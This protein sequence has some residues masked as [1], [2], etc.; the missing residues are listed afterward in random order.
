MSVVCFIDDLLFVSKIRNVAQSL[1]VEIHFVSLPPADTTEFILEKNASRVIIDLNANKFRPID[2]IRAIN[3]IPGGKPN[4]VGFVS[5]VNAELI[6]M[7]RQEG[8]LVLPRSKFLTELDA[9]LR[10]AQ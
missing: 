1:G 5:H 10:G 4:I 2:L 9:I 7:A 6:E 3:S 8:C